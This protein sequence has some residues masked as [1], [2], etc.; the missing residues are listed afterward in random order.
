MAKL[1]EPLLTNLITIVQGNMLSALNTINAE[2]ADNVPL[3]PPGANAYY[4]GPRV[5]IPEYPALTFEVVS[6]EIDDEQFGNTWAVMRHQV[7]IDIYCWSDTEANLNK[8]LLRYARAVWVILYGNQSE[9]VAA[10][11]SAISVRPRRGL[12]SPII[13]GARGLYK[14]WRWQYEIHRFDDLSS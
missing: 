7:H 6:S 3:P 1:G 8:Q 10:G 5:E 9:T 4:H 14:L 13:P 2:Y 12:M 11:A